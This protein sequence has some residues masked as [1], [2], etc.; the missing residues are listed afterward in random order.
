LK[1]GVFLE[2]VSLRIQGDCK[3]IGGH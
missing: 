2:P 3:A 1:Q